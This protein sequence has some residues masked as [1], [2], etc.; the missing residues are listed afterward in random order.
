VEAAVTTHKSE[1]LRETPNTLIQQ[2]TERR[3]LEVQKLRVE[4]AG[5]SRSPFLS[6]AVIIPAVAALVTLGI[7]AATG[8]FDTKRATIQ[9]QID[10]LEIKKSHSQDDVA[11]VQA[12]LAQKTNEFAIVQGKLAQTT[13]ELD[14]AVKKNSDA[15]AENETLRGQR[16]DL[17]RAVDKAKAD[18]DITRK[19]LGSPLLQADANLDYNKSL[20]LTIRNVGLGAAVIRMQRVFVDN[21]LVPIGHFMS[22]GSPLLE[23]LSINDSVHGW[24]RFNPDASLNTGDSQRFLF[25][26][27]PATLRDE[28]QFAAILRRVG[29][30]ICYCSLM[31][32]SCKWVVFNRS[33]P[34]DQCR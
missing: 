30:E 21:D 15:M 26:D 8:V 9:N 3:E 33:T 17:Q 5:L 29:V 1:S 31:S 18:L 11:K 16:V 14:S 10:L 6:P 20:A 27:A 19:T 12:D 32:D 13:Q 34:P 28:Q 7:T 25:R 22:E 23:R 4:I 24:G 2:D